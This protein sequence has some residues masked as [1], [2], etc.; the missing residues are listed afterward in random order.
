MQVGRMH[1]RLRPKEV[2]DAD[3]IVNC[4]VSDEMRGL[5]ETSYRFRATGSILL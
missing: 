3:E 4:E 5:F 2:H 1:E